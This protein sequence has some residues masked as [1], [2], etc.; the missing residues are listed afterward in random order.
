MCSLH[1]LS[2]AFRPGMGVICGLPA[3]RTNDDFAVD[4]CKKRMNKARALPALDLLKAFEAAARHLPFTRAAAELFLSQSAVSRQ[5]QQLEAQ[6]GLPLFIRRTRAL[7]LTAAGQR[8]FR[9]VSQ[10]L[11]QL[12]AAGAN[13][14]AAADSR[15][16]N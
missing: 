1:V 16:V 7:L 2:G 8:Y 3:R 10:A 6:L 13:L 9:D 12:R 11:H 15:I 4:G 5:I 14:H